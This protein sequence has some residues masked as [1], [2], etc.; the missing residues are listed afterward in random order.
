MAVPRSDLFDAAFFVDA[1]LPIGEPENQDDED[2]QRS[3][4]RHVEAQRKAEDHDLVERH[5]EKV[6]Y[7]AE[8]QPDREGGKHQRTGAPPMLRG[9]HRVDC[10][11]PGHVVC[12]PVV[13]RSPTVAAS[14]KPWPRPETTH[15]AG[16]PRLSLPE[17]LLA[18]WR[19]FLFPL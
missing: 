4:R 1:V 16:E 3:L 17:R 12:I 7:E 2:D 19:T 11:G 15:H 9:A 5:H 6:N 13:V 8:E 10:Q 18:P 14:A